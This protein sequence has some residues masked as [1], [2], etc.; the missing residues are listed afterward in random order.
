MDRWDPTARTRF[1]TFSQPLALWRKRNSRSGVVEDINNSYYKWDKFAS[2][3]I[4]ETP[5]GWT[6]TTSSNFE[7]SHYQSDSTRLKGL[8]HYTAYAFYQPLP[9]NSGS[10]SP[11]SISW[12]LL[13]SGIVQ[14]AKLTVGEVLS[15]SQ[16]IELCRYD[17][18]GQWA[19]VMAT[20]FNDTREYTNVHECFVTTVCKATRL[21]VEGHIHPYEEMSTRNQT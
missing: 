5:Q 20:C 7:G 10:S 19:G 8:D 6:R 15:Q 16:P 1:R 9:I 3:C 18:S 4:G 14:A 2:T 13:L 12:D 11:D 17:G 21:R